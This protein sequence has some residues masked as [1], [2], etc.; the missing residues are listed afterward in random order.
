MTK[1]KVKS[2]KTVRDDRFPCPHCGTRFPV[3]DLGDHL[4][5]TACGTHLR[6]SLGREF[7]KLVEVND[8][9]KDQQTA[10]EGAVVCVSNASQTTLRLRTSDAGVVTYIPHT[11]A[12]FRLERA[13]VAEFDHRFRPTPEYPPGR[14]ARLYVQYAQLL[15]AT[16]DAIVELRG[17]VDVSDEE[18]AVAEQRL[19]TNKSTRKATKAVATKTGTVRIEV[20]KSKRNSAAEM[21]RGLILEG[22]LADEQILAKVT[23]VWGGNKGLSHVSYYRSQLRKQGL[24][25]PPKVKSVTKGDGREVA[26]EKTGK[27]AAG[28]RP[29]KKASKKSTGKKVVRRKR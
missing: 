15:G 1:K 9:T 24:N 4:D 23:E 14:C 27:P 12:G 10:R 29:R 7:T 20:T 5:R 6:T 16:T 17:L 26:S 19:G 25:P 13:P 22:Q 21:F 18:Q 8:P 2:A 3:Q 11:P 28:R